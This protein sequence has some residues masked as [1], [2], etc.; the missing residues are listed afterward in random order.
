MP[1]PKQKHPR[2]KLIATA[3]SRTCGA[4][5]FGLADADVT[6]RACSHETTFPWDPRIMNPD[7]IHWCHEQAACTTGAALPTTA[8][9]YCGRAAREND[10]CIKT[11]QH[12]HCT[13]V[14]CDAVCEAAYHF[15]HVLTVVE[16]GLE[17]KE[18]GFGPAADSQAATMSEP[19]VPMETAA[20]AA[21]VVVVP[22]ADNVMEPRREGSNWQARREHIRALVAQQRQMYQQEQQQHEQSID[23]QNTQGASK[24]S[25]QQ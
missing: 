4:C 2:R 18:A 16:I 6:C 20:A 3:H 13:R 17:A 22:V 24:R 5:G 7:G 23:E 11:L 12:G 8:C 10:S 1:R 25:R 21:V 14:V 9:A 15:Q 19:P